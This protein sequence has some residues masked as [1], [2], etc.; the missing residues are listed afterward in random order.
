MIL[1]MHFLVLRAMIL[2]H[3]M[4]LVLSLIINWCITS[5]FC[6]H[7][8]IVVQLM[9]LALWLAL[10]WKK[11]RQTASYQIGV[12]VH[13]V[14]P[15]WVDGMTSFENRE[16]ITLSG[17]S[18]RDL[19]NIWWL[20]HVSRRGSGVNGEQNG[21]IAQVMMSSWVLQDQALSHMSQVA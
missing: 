2:Y 19:E 11:D 9:I 18:L 5:A 8:C 10:S 21:H 20:D 6:I 15:L 14:L 4:I 3:I 17:L 13:H 1:S 16:A 12:D 7:K